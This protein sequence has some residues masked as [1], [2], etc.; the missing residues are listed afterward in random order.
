MG[1]VQYS[2]APLYVKLGYYVTKF[3]VDI[4]V[5][6]VKTRWKGLRDTFRKQYKVSHPTNKSGAGAEEEDVE[7]DTGMRWHYY[8]SMMFLKDVMS[9]PRYE[10]MYSQLC[11]LIQV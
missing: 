4:S 2:N 1:N 11:S 7:N 3:I 9:S 6:E 10:C 8:A 5:E